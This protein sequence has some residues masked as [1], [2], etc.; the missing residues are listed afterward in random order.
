MAGP[1]EHPNP[2][3]VK[4]DC[5]FLSG[6]SNLSTANYIHAACPSSSNAQ[7]QN[8]QDSVCECT[9][10]QNKFPTY[11]PSLGID[12]GKCVFPPV[13]LKWLLP[14][15]LDGLRVIILINPLLRPENKLIS[16]NTINS[17]IPDCLLHKRMM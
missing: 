9:H 7:L 17:Y 15:P 14:L 4:P 8:T 1:S 16:E 10:E 6:V 13:L 12:I 2:R 11:L 3:W 5:A